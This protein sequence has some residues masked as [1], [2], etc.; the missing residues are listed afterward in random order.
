[1]H[2]EQMFP[3]NETVGATL[4]FRLPP[5]F[6]GVDAQPKHTG[7]CCKATEGLNDC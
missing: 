1:M 2:L 4:A 5:P 7:R 6:Y 3:R